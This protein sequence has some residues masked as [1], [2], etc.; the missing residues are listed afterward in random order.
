MQ[1]T[2]IDFKTNNIFMIYTNFEP[3]YKK[4]KFISS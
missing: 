2:L 1:Y 4:N 3:P